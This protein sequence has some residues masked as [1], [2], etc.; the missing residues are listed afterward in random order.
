MPILQGAVTFA[1]FRAEPL[2]PQPKDVRRAFAKDLR[3]RGFAPLDKLGEQERAT[4][5]VELHDHDSVGLSPARFLFDGRLLVAYRVDTR[6]VPSATVRRNLDDW[7]KDYQLRQGRPPKRTERSEQ[8]E[9]IIKRLRKQAFIATQTID[10]AW[11][12]DTDNITIWSSTRKLIDEVHIALEETFE[13]RLK[14][15]SPGALAEA[16]GA[17]DKV[18]APSKALFGAEI[19]HLEPLDVEK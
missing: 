3:G 9:L 15:I 13:I 4:G 19:D 6:R 5:W 1:R 17:S 7:A 10:V 2:K 8:K 11:N 16:T 14:P 18:L 12:L